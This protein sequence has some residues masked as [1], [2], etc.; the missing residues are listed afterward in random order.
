[1]GLDDVFDEA[2]Y[3]QAGSMHGQK[4]YRSY[5]WRVRLRR[6]GWIAIAFL[7]LVAYHV[8]RS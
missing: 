7:A 6:L 4:H 1:M 2:A 3:S 5:L 8:G